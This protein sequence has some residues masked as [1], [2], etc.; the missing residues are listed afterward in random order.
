MYKYYDVIILD[1]FPF[2]TL[3]NQVRVIRRDVDL[4]RDVISQMEIDTTEKHIFS[5][6]LDQLT[7]ASGLIPIN[8]IAIKSIL[9]ENRGLDYSNFINQYDNTLLYLVKYNQIPRPPKKILHNF[10]LLYEQNPPLEQLEWSLYKHNWDGW[11]DAGIYITTSNISYFK[12]LPLPVIA[13]DATAEAQAWR[14]LLNDDKCRFERIDIEY[15][16]LYQTKTYARYP[17]SSWVSIENNKQVLS[18]AGI[19]LCKLIKNI[20]S[21]KKEKVLVCSNKRIRG[22]INGYLTREEKDKI[23]FAIYYNLRSRNDFYEDCDTCIIAHE[24]N[25]PPLQLEIMANVTQWGTD[26]LRDLMTKD[27]ILQAIGRIRQNILS[28]PYGRK[29][30]LI[31]IYVIPGSM[32]NNNKIVA[33]AKL[34]PYDNLMVGKLLSVSDILKQTMKNST[35]SFTFEQ[36]RSVTKELCSRRALQTIIDNLE[37]NKYISRTRGCIKWSFDEGEALKTNYIRLTI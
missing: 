5:R 21:R 18:E 16:K 17:V 20:C 28:T 34:V 37:I 13:L 4:M 27:E 7:L 11:M 10:K 19:R 33:E 36:L 26:L 12:K 32:D 30:E 23:I 29:R 24:P 3:F 25:I 14:T 9:D 22:L 1:E 8:H 35:K 31:E 6:F 2:Q 15:K